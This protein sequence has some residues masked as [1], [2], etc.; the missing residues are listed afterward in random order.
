M[1]LQQ[2]INSEVEIFYA[3]ELFAISN[4]KN[5]DLPI[6]PYKINNDNEYKIHPMIMARG[7]EARYYYLKPGEKLMT[8]RR[9][10]GGFFYEIRLCQA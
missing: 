2:Y 7:L 6:Y 8:A 3:R 10:Y 1:R 9:S 5:L 4:E